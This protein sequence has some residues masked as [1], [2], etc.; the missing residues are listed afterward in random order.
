MK[1]PYDYINGAPFDSSNEEHVKEVIRRNKKLENILKEGIELCHD[2]YVRITA[3]VTFECPKCGTN[4]CS[5]TT[6]NYHGYADEIF[7]ELPNVTCK[8]CRTHYSY[9]PSEER[10]YIKN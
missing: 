7:N 4:V 2:C 10:F 1:R 3:E 8:C 9:N 5:E 6:E